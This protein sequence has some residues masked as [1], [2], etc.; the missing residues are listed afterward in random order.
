MKKLKVILIQIAV[1]RVSLND[2]RIVKNNIPLA[3]GYLKAFAHKKGLLKNCDI[4]ILEYKYQDLGGDSFLIKRLI[5]SSPD[6]IG[7]SIYPWNLSRSLFMASEIK[8][9]NPEIILIAGGPEVDEN[10][11]VI[12]KSSPIDIFVIG[13]G[14]VTFCELLEHFIY[15]KPKLQEINGIIYKKDNK[16]LTTP[17]RDLIQNL[18]DIPSPYQLGFIKPENHNY[19]MWLEAQRGCFFNCKYC[20]WPRK[21]PHRKIGSSLERL[22]QE[23]EF[24]R[25][26]KVK[27]I[28]F[29]DGSFNLV[30]N[31]TD[32]CKLIKEINYDKKIAF[33]ASC[34][35]DFINPEIAKLLADCNFSI[36]SI[37]LQSSN[38]NVLKNISRKTNMQKFIQAIRCMRE[39]GIKVMI[40]VILGLPGET[41][42]TFKETLNFLTEN[43]L[44]DVFEDDYLVKGYKDDDCQLICYPLSVAQGTPLRKEISKWGFRIQSQPSYRILETSTFSFNELKE[45]IKQTRK[46]GY[47]EPDVMFNFTPLG[48]AAFV[49]GVYP[50]AEE[51]LN[52]SGKNLNI[53]NFEV[54]LTK[55][56]LEIDHSQ[57]N[58]EQISGLALKLHF[59]LARTITVWFKCNDL[60]KEKELIFA[61]LKNVSQFNPHA[62]WNIIVET[63]TPF[64]LN[65][66]EEIKEHIYYLPN[67]LDYEGIFFAEN[68][69]QEFL[70]MSAR[71]FTVLSGKNNFDA[72][73]LT[74]LDRITPYY[75]HLSYPKESVDDLKELLQSKAKG[76]LIDFAPLL[77]VV[78]IIEVLNYIHINN[79]SNK[80]IFFTNWVI[81]RVWDIEYRKYTETLG[82]EENI[83]KVDSTLKNQN[84][85]T[86][87]KTMLSEQLA[88]WL[89][90][91]KELVK[92]N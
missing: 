92:K 78:E 79:N 63:S 89:K 17:P 14:E 32:I 26:N 16:V 81:Q 20:S 56:I 38:E 62:V 82:T 47:F 46:V 42:Q 8:K 3:A 12:S 55:I 39:Y 68:A 54:P 57:Q 18:N 59:Q 88:E 6:V 35:A 11:P 85:T 86:F 66:I 80:E 52:C 19:F 22:R 7:F 43:K 53:N 74:Q 31:F 76:I 13:E 33:S 40:S 84:I 36:I 90:S 34:Y 69:K 30:S 70:R 64:S 23:L 9:A 73:W 65:L 21:G 50:Y 71:I 44:V 25:N 45:A 15:K 29:L 28:S 75:R 10:N 27:L 72:I 61:F 1:S 49:Q 67:Y 2:I 83:L 37:G 24:A 5:D 77:T 4:D 51:V 41:P 58:I 87:N 60:P 48:F 91:R